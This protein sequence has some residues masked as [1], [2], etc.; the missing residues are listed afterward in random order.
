MSG[1]EQK[2]LFQY[3]RVVGTKFADALEGVGVT[4][5]ELD[6]HLSVE[7]RN[8]SRIFILIPRLILHFRLY[9]PLRKRNFEFGFFFE[10][11]SDAPCGIVGRQLFAEG[12]GGNRNI[13]L[14]HELWSETQITFVAWASTPDAYY[15]FL[16]KNE[17]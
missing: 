2:S 11:F 8:I 10:E 9:D 7:K 17:K 1:E 3:P 14:N 13:P 12:Y 6:R 15:D 16:K 4:L 5:E